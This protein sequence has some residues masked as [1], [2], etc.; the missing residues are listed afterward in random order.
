M[1][2]TP[3]LIPRCAINIEQ[4]IKK[5][6][7]ITFVEHTD[8]EH[9]SNRFL[10]SVKDQ[11]PDA[12][13]HCWARVLGRPDDSMRY[14]FSDDGEPSGTAGK[15]MLQQLIG[16]NIGEI[17]AVVVRYFGGVKLGKGGLVRAYSSSVQLAVD[18][19][20]TELKIAMETIQVV[21]PF[22]LIGTFEHLIKEHQ[23]I[24]ESRQYLDTLLCTVRLPV[25]NIGA[26]ELVLQEKSKGKAN[27]KKN[28]P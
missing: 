28:Q 27:I 16:A 7:F 23:G 20:K 4:E 12:R 14:G 10:Q 5:S 15:P 13:H 24:I 8:S 3:Y 21:V 25:S 9:V 1:T 6:R 22:D 26:F 19:L 17:T 18:E 11:F 2:Q